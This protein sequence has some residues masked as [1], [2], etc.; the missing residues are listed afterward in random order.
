MTAP[1][2]PT[3][4]TTHAV[5]KPPTPHPTDLVDDL[6]QAQRPAREEVAAL[7]DL[8]VQRGDVR[9]G[10]VADV[11]DCP[12][13]FN[14][15]EDARDELREELDGEGVRVVLAEEGAEDEA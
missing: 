12:G 9:G 14:G 4:P 10:H 3:T 7:N 8:G 1:I 11:D 5:P 2:H 15:R 13:E 6:A